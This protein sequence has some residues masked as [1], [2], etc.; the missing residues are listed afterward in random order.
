MKFI[1]A[2]QTNKFSIRFDINFNIAVENEIYIHTCDRDD[3]EKK[4]DHQLS[5]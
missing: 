2:V 4:F 1:G 3:D 5:I